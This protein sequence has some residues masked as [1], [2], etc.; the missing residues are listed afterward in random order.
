[1][2]AEAVIS[3]RPESDT[4]LRFVRK[5]SMQLSSKM[6]F[7]AA[8][9]VALLTDDLWLRNAQH[10]NAM[11]QRLGSTA[12]AVP[13]VK[14]AYPVQANGVFAVLPP[15]VTEALQAD[16]PFYVWDARTGV[17]RW[18]TSFDTTEDDVDRFAGRLGELMNQQT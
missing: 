13:G 10:A 3:F 11:A 6:R 1:M 5:Q 15:A 16:Y 8:Q 2:G 17:V 12:S 14:L 18:M 7:A 4:G 9:F